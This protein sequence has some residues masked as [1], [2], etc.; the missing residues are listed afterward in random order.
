MTNGALLMIICF[1]LDWRTQEIQKE[2][3][4]ITADDAVT[5]NKTHFTN[6]K[7]QTADTYKN[8]SFKLLATFI[9]H[10]VVDK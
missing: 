2:R 3:F 9:K 1:H 6:Y 8:N 10:Y 5:E 4:V 7:I